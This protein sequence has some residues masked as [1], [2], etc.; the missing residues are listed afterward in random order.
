[1]AVPVISMLVLVSQDVSESHARRCDQFP[2]LPEIRPTACD[3]PFPVVDAGTLEAANTSSHGDSLPFRLSRRSGQGR[4]S[5]WKKRGSIAVAALRN[6]ALLVVLATN[7]IVLLDSDGT[8]WNDPADEHAEV[9][10]VPGAMVNQDGTMSMML[11]DRVTRPR[12]TGTA[13]SRRSS[14]RGPRPMDP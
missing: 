1:M 2:S 11:A 14:F 9:V 10:T 4:P 12:S 3:D 6:I 8:V 7:L 5:P 13:R